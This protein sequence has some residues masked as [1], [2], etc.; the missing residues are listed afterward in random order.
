[1][2]ME[3]TERVPY[4]SNLEDMFR[5]R[6]K[7]L[8]KNIGDWIVAKWDASG[9]KLRRYLYV[10]LIILIAAGIGEIGRAHV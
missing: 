8:K 2:R 7:N 6:G 10:F 5:G 1:M 3:T 4:E 9:R